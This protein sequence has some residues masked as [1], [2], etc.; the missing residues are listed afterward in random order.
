MRSVGLPASQGS[1][2][3]FD[4]VFIPSDLQS[5]RLIKHYPKKLYLSISSSEH[6]EFVLYRIVWFFGI[7]PRKNYPQKMS[8]MCAGM[9]GR[10]EGVVM[11]Y[12]ELCRLHLQTAA[13]KTTAQLF[14]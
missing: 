7:D 12:P 14:L 1:L 6:T 2:A 8:K 10:R 11:Q 5:A 9:G 4:F 13:A 3:L